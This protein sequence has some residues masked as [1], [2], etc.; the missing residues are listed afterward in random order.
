MRHKK[1]ALFSYFVGDEATQ[2]GCLIDPAFETGRILDSVRQTGFTV[3]HIVNTHGHADHVAG[4]HAVQQA[5]GAV[6]ALHRED[7]PGLDGR[8]NR[9]FVRLLGGKPSPP[10]DVLLEDGSLVTL[11]KTELHVI[12]TPGH[13]VG[14]ICL[15]GEGHLFTGDT[16]FVG[17]VGRTDLPGSSEVRL[18]QSLHDRILS[19]PGDTRVWPGHDY[20]VEPSSTVRQ[21]QATNAY[22]RI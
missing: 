17:G 8:M 19:L 16:L 4:N 11:G 3:T 7:A 12:H 14:S 2:T 20:G 18:R 6:L 15:Y 1:M 22:L 5:T 9:I 21:E 13:T 10:P